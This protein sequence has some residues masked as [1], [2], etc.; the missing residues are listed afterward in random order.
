MYELVYSTPYVP[1]WMEDKQKLG[2]PRETMLK[3]G[4]PY[5][6]HVV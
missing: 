3:D 4:I 2:C 5:A 1:Y 6:N